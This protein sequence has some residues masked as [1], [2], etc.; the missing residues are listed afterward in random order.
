MTTS[1]AHLIFHFARVVLDDKSIFLSLRFLV[2]WIVF[3][4]VV[5]LVQKIFVTATR[6]AT[7]KNFMFKNKA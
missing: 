3:V 4:N 5:K 6:E 2:K 1:I 7:K